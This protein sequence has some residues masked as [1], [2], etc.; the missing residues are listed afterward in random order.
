METKRCPY[1]AEE[2]LAEAVRCKFCRS[3]LTSFEPER[4]H[5]SHPEAR[6]AGVC[7][8]LARAFA[9]P[10]GAV[11]L[12]FLVLTF[13][14]FIGPVL[15]AGL[16]LVIPHRPGEES[17]LERLMSW[18]LEAAAKLSGRDDGRPQPPTVPRA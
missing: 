16:F 13:V 10:V 11:R 5:R 9:V 8:A 1:C 4:W 15:Y 3:R 7:S 14:H 17:L 2:I 18:G 6:L 12:V